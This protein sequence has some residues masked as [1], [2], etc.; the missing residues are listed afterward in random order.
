M[1]LRDKVVFITGAAR[2]IGA[3]LARETAA[4][5]A[6]VVLTGVETGELEARA[7]ELGKPHIVVPCDVTDPAALEAAAQ[8]AV[9]EF[10][11]IDV[12]VANA[13]IA[14]YGTVEKGDAAAWLRTVDVNL[15]GVYHTARATLPSLLARKGYF[16]GIASVASYIPMPGSSSYGASKAG[17]ESLV[18]ALRL[19]VGHRGV[20]CGTAHPSWID[21][22]LVRESDADL[23]A[24][25]ERRAS[26]P[27]PLGVTTDLDTCVRM[28]TDGI[29][30]RRHRIHVPRSAGAIYWLRSLLGRLA[31]SRRA[32]REAGEGVAQMEADIEKLGRAASARTHEINQ[33]SAGS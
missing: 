2:G 9:E 12:V 8:T 20:D 27:W 17:V 19:E 28:I 22:D 23:P 24:F 21:T 16:C 3:G 4:R 1:T 33:G 30:A 14:T 11:G 15:H 13:G 6:R 5:G 32:L 18:G 10:G 29:E 31:A 26:M 25:R 7:N